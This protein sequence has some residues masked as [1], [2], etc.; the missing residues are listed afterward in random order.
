M[1]TF[2][3]RFFRL[4]GDKGVL[5]AACLIG[6]AI[7]EAHDLGRRKR[8]AVEHFRLSEFSVEIPQKPNISVI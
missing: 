2:I 5:V 4:A 3:L 6:L 7:N 1:I 8:Q